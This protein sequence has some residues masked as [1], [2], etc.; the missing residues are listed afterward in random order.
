MTESIRHEFEQFRDRRN[1]LLDPK[2]APRD[3]DATLGAGGVL[4]VGLLTGGGYP[5]AAAVVSVLLDLR[6]PDERFPW[7]REPTP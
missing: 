6:F 3:R 2:T 1:E 4:A 5:G 7:S